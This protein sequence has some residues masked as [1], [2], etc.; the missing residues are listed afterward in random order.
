MGARDF[1]DVKPF[2]L[3]TRRALRARTLLERL[4]GSVRT[5]L[6]QGVPAPDFQFSRAEIQT[7]YRSLLPPP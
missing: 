2:D 6:E 3:S 4:A 1:K 7:H 5:G